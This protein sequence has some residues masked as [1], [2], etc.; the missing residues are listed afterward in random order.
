MRSESKTTKVR[1]V[2]NGSKKS[3]S[4][5]SLNNVL[6]PG[7]I[8]QADIMKIIFRWRHYKFVFTGDIEKMYHQIRVHKPECAYQRILF[9]PYPQDVVKSFELKTV[10]FGINCAPFLAIRS[11]IQ[12]SKDCKELNPKASEILRN[13]VYVDDVLSGGHNLDEAKIKQAQLMQT[14]RQ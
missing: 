7:P 2:F 11:L 10:T 4:G 8:L 9:R 6:Y 5:L 13:E 14:Q 12:L 3:S 1:V